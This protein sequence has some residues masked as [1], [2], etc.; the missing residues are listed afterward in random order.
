MRYRVV[1]D[2]EGHCYLIPAE[3]LDEWDAFVGID[4]DDEASWTVPEWAQQIDG[5]HLLTFADPVE[6]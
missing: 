2:A 6:E 4:S 3:N 1:Y 5:V